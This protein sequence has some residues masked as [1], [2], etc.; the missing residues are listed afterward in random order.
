MNTPET[1]DQP[2]P[3]VASSALL[4]DLTGRFQKF[5]IRARIFKNLPA[6]L[7]D[8]D[9]DKFERLKTERLQ[10]EIAIMAEALDV[11]K[12]LD[13]IMSANAQAQRPPPQR[14]NNTETAPGGSLQRICSA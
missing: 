5:N 4:A 9:R 13:A 6:I 1:T 3:A 7:L 2:A 11:M 14:L 10:E 8:G 12:G